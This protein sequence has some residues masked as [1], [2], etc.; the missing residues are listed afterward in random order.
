MVE[1][2]CISCRNPRDMI[3][4]T[5]LQGQL[6]VNMAC[7]IYLNHDATRNFIYGLACHKCRNIPII[8]LYKMSADPLSHLPVQAE[9]ACEAG[10]RRQIKKGD[11]EL[12]P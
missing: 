7:G 2:W 12:P 11:E 9:E 1:H 8:H 5:T 4:Q 10:E 3:P 6:F